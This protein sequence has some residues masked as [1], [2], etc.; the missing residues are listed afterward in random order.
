MI[1]NSILCYLEGLLQSVL[2]SAGFVDRQFGQRGMTN[3]Y[4]LYDK[5][6]TLGCL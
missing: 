6:S 1:L 4:H 5:Y 3:Y 2:S